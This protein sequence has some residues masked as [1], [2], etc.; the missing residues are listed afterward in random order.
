MCR[1]H[2]GVSPHF[3]HSRHGAGDASASGWGLT[4]EVGG[5]ERLKAE[6]KSKVQ[7][8]KSVSVKDNVICGA[9]FAGKVCIIID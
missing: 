5:C 7:G 9:E 1:C 4:A 2:A 3:L 8:L 6:A